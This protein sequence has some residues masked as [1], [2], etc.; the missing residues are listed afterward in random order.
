MAG[1]IRHW[2]HGIFTLVDHC[3]LC[4]LCLKMNGC[5]FWQSH[6]KIYQIFSVLC[7]LLYCWLVISATGR[8][9]LY[10]I[11][12]S[13]VLGG[14]SYWE[15]SSHSGVLASLVAQTV[16][17]AVCNSGDPGLIPGSGSPGEGNGNPLQYSC[18]E[19]LMDRGAGRA[20]VHRV[21]KSQPWLKPLSTYIAQILLSGL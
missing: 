6:W 18:L 10:R 3:S 2:P 15:S 17:A 8:Q 5:L 20:T 16:K 4:W 11:N 12:K 1:G 7:E 13:T 21:A 19:N 9:S 14:L